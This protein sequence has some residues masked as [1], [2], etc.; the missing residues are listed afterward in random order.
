MRKMESLVRPASPT[1]L[2]WTVLQTITSRSRCDR[3]LKEA[4]SERPQDAYHEAPPVCAGAHSAEP[5]E[6]QCLAV[7]GSIHAGW[8]WASVTSAHAELDHLNNVFGHRHVLQLI[9]Q[10]GAGAI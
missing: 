5:I 4:G 1:F 9:C 10:F 8:P 2:Q 7:V 6:R 3:R